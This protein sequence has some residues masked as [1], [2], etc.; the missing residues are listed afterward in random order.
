MESFASGAVRI[1]DEWFVNKVVRDVSFHGQFCPLLLFY[2]PLLTFKG[3]SALSQ[4][5]FKNRKKNQI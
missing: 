2:F 4:T 1:L 3:K 5:F